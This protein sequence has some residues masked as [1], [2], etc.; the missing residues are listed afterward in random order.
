MSS[1]GSFCLILQLLC[2][3]LPW[4]T[5]HK[6]NISETSCSYLLVLLLLL[7]VMWIRIDCIR[8]WIQFRIRIQINKITKF[9]KQNLIF[10][11]QVMHLLPETS[12]PT[13]L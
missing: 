11:S 7:S 13:F 9:S 12:A 6:E 2:N 10:K 1:S 4:N 3:L 8:I 5:K